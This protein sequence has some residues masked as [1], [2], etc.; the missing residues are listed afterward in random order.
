MNL[1]QNGCDGTKIMTVSGVVIDVLKPE[2]SLI[3]IGDI[4]HSLSNQC[5]FIGHFPSFYSVGIHS[6]LAAQLS[7]QNHDPASASL[8]VL[9]HDSAEAYVGDM[10]KPI[11]QLFPAFSDIENKILEAIGNRFWIRFDDHKELIKKY[12]LQMLHWEQWVR[13]NGQYVPRDQL[14]GATDRFL[15]M[16]GVLMK[17][18]PADVTSVFLNLFDYLISF[19]EKPV[20][21]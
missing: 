7:I 5:R 6:I 16:S 4:A 18:C 14:V 8:A 21:R 2:S 9:M 12:D 10:P 17:S 13:S 11:K 15:W 3:N 1:N 19:L 20:G